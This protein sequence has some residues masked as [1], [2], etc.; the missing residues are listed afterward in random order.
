VTWTS[1]DPG[2]GDATCIR[3]RLYKADGVA[4]GKDFLVDT[5]AASSQAAPAVAAL[6]DGRFVVTWLSQDAGDGNGTC[7]RARLYNADGSAAGNDFVV[8]TTAAS[9]QYNPTIVALADGRFIVSWE[10]GDTGDGSSGCVRAQIFDPTVFVGTAGEDSWQGANFADR[11]NGGASSDTLSGLGGNDTVSGD[12]GKDVLSGGT[13]DDRLFGGADDDTLNGNTGA[14]FMAGGSGNDFFLV[15]SA[16]DTVVEVAGQGADR[17]FAS[18]SY[19]LKAGSA[20]ETLSTANS[21]GT[22]AI[23]LTGNAFANTV[24]GNAGVNVLNGGGGADTM[25]GLGGNDV[26]VVDNAGDIVSEAGGH[27]VDKVV[28]LIG[29]SLA[30]TTH[31]LGAVEN[32]TLAG[33]AAIN[34][35]GN[36]LANSIVGNAAANILSGGRGNDLL[37]GAAGN[38]ILIGGA[39]N[40]RLIGG[41]GNDVFVFADPLRTAN[42]DVVSDFHNRSHDNDTFYLDNTVFTKLGAGHAHAL[43]P[44]F[45]HAGHAA[46]DAN[47]FVV[48]DKATGALFYDVNG[49]AAGGAVQI[50][51]LTDRPVLTARDFVVVHDFLVL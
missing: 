17:V 43:N 50:A 39:G 18:V 2:D 38:D 6:A 25:Q 49:S 12:G 20:V 32:L 51:M 29:F 46:A 31:V 24:I 3:G 1:S 42:R 27:G 34:G 7:I 44:A 48:Y 23:N 26:Y 21:A 35:A 37:N 15:D 40:D 30:D 4:A 11:I 16:A 8:N 22:T 10:S 13:G 41:A 33:T 5:T 28:S 9:D 19:T 47:D 45:F 14:D 36:S